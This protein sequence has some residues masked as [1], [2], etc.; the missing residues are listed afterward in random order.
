MRYDVTCK[1]GHFQSVETM[2]EA[3]SVAI[4]MVKKNQRQVLVQLV[5][6][7][8]AVPVFP[9]ETESEIANKIFDAVQTVGTN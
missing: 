8:R 7:G 1:A 6:K 3:M 2:R 5:D 9:G 4:D